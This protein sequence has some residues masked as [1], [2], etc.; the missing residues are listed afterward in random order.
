MTILARKGAKFDAS[1][2]PETKIINSPWPG[3]AG[4][5]LYGLFWILIHRQD[6]FD[7]V[8]TEPTVLG[9][10]GFWAKLVGACRKWAVDI[11][12]IPIRCKFRDNKLV[13]WRCRLIR[14]LIKFLY[15]WTDLFIISILPDYELKEFNIPRDKMVLLKNAIWLNDELTVHHHKNN[16]NFSLICMRSI[17]Y[18]DMGLDTLCQAFLL[19]KDKIQN[20]SLKI[21]GRIPEVIKHQV[22]PILNHPGV[23]FYNFVHF[24]E[25]QQMIADS[26]VTVIP[27]KNTPDLAQTY[28]I[29]ILEY[30]RLGKVIVCSNIEG[31][32]RMIKN[33][34][35]GVLFQ[36]GNAEDLAKKILTLYQDKQIYNKIANNALLIDQ[37]FNCEWKNRQI[38][39]KLNKIL[40]NQS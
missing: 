5:L 33:Y 40:K 7:V 1:A 34:Q 19:L 37:E 4:Q 2:A 13:V 16:H 18:E 36:A 29:K 3:K 8:L 39:Q 6:K 23:E 12:D 24:T 25:L 27:F 9:I 11:W 22:Q 35:N 26:A 10:L 28:P 32:S 17:Y 30:L 38:F 21:V 31:M 15:K 14:S 20:L